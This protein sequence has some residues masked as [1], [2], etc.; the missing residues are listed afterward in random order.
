LHRPENPG[1]VDAAL[2]EARVGEYL[3]EDD[4]KRI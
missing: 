3:G 4:F 1:K 2:V